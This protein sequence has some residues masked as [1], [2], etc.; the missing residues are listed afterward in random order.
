MNRIKEQK[1]A[2]LEGNLTDQELIKITGG[3][4]FVSIEDIISKEPPIQALYGISPNP[5][6]C[7]PLYG[8]KP[9][10][11]IRPMYGVPITKKLV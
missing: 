11:D 3:E 8:I 2:I 9:P 7:Y 4:T 10:I 5:P 1:K 6:I